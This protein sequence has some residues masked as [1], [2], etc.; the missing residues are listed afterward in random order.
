[1]QPV[2]EP[3]FH[4]AQSRER[5]YFGAEARCRVGQFRGC[6]KQELFTVIKQN[7]ALQKEITAIRLLIMNRAV[8]L[9]IK[10][11]TVQIEPGSRAG[12]DQSLAIYAGA[13]NSI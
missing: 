7:L 12:S 4:N 2:G 5:P 8:R 10:K 13:A 11:L 6:R 9:A 1:M 3:R